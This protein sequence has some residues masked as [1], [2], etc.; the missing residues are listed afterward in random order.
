METSGVAMSM[1][2]VSIVA[3]RTPRIAIESAIHLY[4][5]AL[6]I[7]RVATHGADTAV[8]SGSFRNRSVKDEPPAEM[9]R[10]RRSRLARRLKLR[11]SG[12]ARGQKPTERPP[13][14][15]RVWPVMYPAWVEA[16][17]PI[18]AATSVGSPSRPSG[19]RA[20]SSCR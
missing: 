6:S 12:A 17:K 1:I 20:V 11:V 13:Q 2:E 7:M 5:R 15:V 14:T 8:L 19:T 3:S 4:S 9:S 16:R 10:E 18:H